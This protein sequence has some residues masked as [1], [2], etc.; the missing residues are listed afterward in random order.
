[1]AATALRSL[2]AEPRPADATG[3]TRRDWLIVAV[4]AVWSLAELVLRDT[5]AARPLVA[6]A[7]LAVIAP[8]PWRRVHPVAAIGVAF[9]MLTVV[10]AI[11]LLDDGTPG[12]LLNSTAATLLLTYAL[13]R[14]GSGREVA[15]GFFF[16]LVWLPVTTTVDAETAANTV[17]AYGFFLTAGALGAAM[18][19]YAAVRARDVDRAKAQEREQLARDL[20]DTVAHHVSG[21]AIQ[22]QAGRAVAATH[23]ERVVDA[24]AS[25]EDAATRTL[26]ELRAIVG[27][28]RTSDDLERAPQPG[29]ADVE[30]LATDA[31]HPHVTVS[32]S[33]DLD[34]LGPA[35]GPAVYRLAQESVTNARRHARHATQV[36]VAVV[37]EAEGVRVTVEDDGT[38]AVGGR[39]PAGYGLIGMEERA[40]L[41]GGTFQAG[42]VDGHGWRVEA[43]LPRARRP[44]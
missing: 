33:G 9:G 16:V 43:T 40:T 41:L 32:L 39:S 38:P 37:G 44:R 34:D 10:D 28:L 15:T 3:P 13:F 22:A 23:P 6:L 21:I 2:W 7:A 5:L 11:R 8:V 35:V 24:L 20:H 1:M 19:S 31:S 17:G 36:S 29:V 18:R 42:P 26:T 14:W 30:R 27:V 25:I 4:L 12:L